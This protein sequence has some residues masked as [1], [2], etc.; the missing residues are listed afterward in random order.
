MGLDFSV[1][2]VKKLHIVSLPLTRPPERR[3][4]FLAEC[5]GLFA[6]PRKQAHSVRVRCFQGHK[7]IVGSGVMFALLG[8]VFFAMSPTGLDAVDSG[9]PDYCGAAAACTSVSGVVVGGNLP[10]PPK[11][12]ECSERFEEGRAARE[13]DYDSQGQY[14]IHLAMEACPSGCCFI[15]RWS[16][17][18]YTRW[19]D[20]CIKMFLLTFPAIAVGLNESKYESFCYL[21]IGVLALVYYAFYLVGTF[22]LQEKCTAQGHD[23]LSPQQ[24]IHYGNDHVC[25]QIAVTAVMIVWNIVTAIVA[26][27]GGAVAGLL[28][29]PPAA[30]DYADGN[31]DREF[32][33]QDV[34]NS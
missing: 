21:M 24:A 17:V 3:P 19:F 12:T 30:E 20:A 29:K 4:A 22:E 1:A 7:L 10:H 32:D 25:Q 2:H 8:W 16:H 18:E 5:T 23:N 6:L 9:V 34:D 26:I 33:S 31:K 13:I 28:Y 14:V 27:I 11:E 15:P